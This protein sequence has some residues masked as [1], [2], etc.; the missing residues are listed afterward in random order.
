M[1]NDHCRILLVEDD[2]LLWR[3]F[4]RTMEGASC[5]IDLAPRGESALDLLTSGIFDVLIADQLTSDLGGLE[6]LRRARE[7]APGTRRVLLAGP[8]DAAAV[9]EELNRSAGDR[10][11]LLPWT[12]AELRETVSYAAQD[13]PLSGDAPPQG[14]WLPW[15]RPRRP[16]PA[17]PR[18]CSTPTHAPRHDPEVVAC[19]ASRRR[20]GRTRSGRSA[21][22]SVRR[23]RTRHR[24]DGSWGHRRHQRRVGRGDR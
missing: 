8:C 20:A 18:R 22:R 24:G 12:D 16:A 21:G 6:L 9:V 14:A 11:I 4:A 7:I 17:S 13:P 15:A 2:P 19:G 10:L 1:R 3:A 5:T 23:Q